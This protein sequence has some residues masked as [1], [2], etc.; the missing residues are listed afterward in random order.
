VQVIIQNEVEPAHRG[1]FSPLGRCER[2]LAKLDIRIQDRREFSHEHR[3]GLE[4]IPNSDQHGA[5]EGPLP[6]GYDLPILEAR[7]IENPVQQEAVY[8]LICRVENGRSVSGDYQASYYV[9]A[10]LQIEL[11]WPNPCIGVVTE[12][13]PLGHRTSLTST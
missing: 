11:S 1:A 5:V 12:V 4:I 8:D 13:Y 7:E 3:N 9:Q 6:R 10:V 2:G